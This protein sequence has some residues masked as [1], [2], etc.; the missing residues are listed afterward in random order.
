MAG[1][2]KNVVRANICIVLPTQSKEKEERGETEHVTY[3]NHNQVETVE[4]EEKKEVESNLSRQH[5]KESNRS[6]SERAN[7][8]QLNEIAIQKEMHQVMRV[9]VQKR[10]RNLSQ[11]VSRKRRK[12][13]M[14]RTRGV[15]SCFILGHPWM[16]VRHI[17]K[18]VDKV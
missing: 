9:N 13:H 12:M 4:H 16:V 10:K 18:H 17:H 1:I 5:S 2:V 11:A 3:Y 14:K 15:S 7:A 6:T 8:I